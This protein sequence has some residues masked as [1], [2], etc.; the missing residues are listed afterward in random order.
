MDWEW[1]EAKSWALGLEVWKALEMAPLKAKELVKGLVM[2][3][4]ETKS[5]G[6]A[7]ALARGLM[8]GKRKATTL[9]TVWELE[10]GTKLV[11]E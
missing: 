10:M 2:L 1:V 3:R 11:S 7:S 8:R 4:A 6:V 9:V 5:M